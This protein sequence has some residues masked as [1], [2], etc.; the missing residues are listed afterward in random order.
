M[1]KIN[2][3]SGAGASRMPSMH[4]AS[5]YSTPKVNTKLAIN[6]T[7]RDDRKLATKLNVEKLNSYKRL[8]KQNIVQMELKRITALAKQKRDIQRQ[9]QNN[10]TKNLYQQHPGL[11]PIPRYQAK[12]QPQKNSDEYISSLPTKTI[13][14][15]QDMAKLFNQIMNGDAPAVSQQEQPVDTQVS[16]D[17]IEL[18]YDQMINKIKT[19]IIDQKNINYLKYIQIAINLKKQFPTNNMIKSIIQKSMDRYN[20]SQFF[21]IPSDK[22][23]E[24]IDII[25]SFC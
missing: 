6:K 13:Q 5:P 8:T 17:N 15:Q 25:L 10:N 18:K 16:L 22:I 14:T 11:P 21:K 12:Q 4:S 23:K 9:P 20:R 2:R 24:V 1:F 7:F 3:R 19:Q